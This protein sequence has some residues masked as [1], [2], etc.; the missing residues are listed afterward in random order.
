MDRHAPLP[1]AG[2]PA[3]NTIIATLACGSTSCPTVYHTSGGSFLV[4]GRSVAPES[5]GVELAD[6]EALVEL[7]EGLLDLLRKG[8]RRIE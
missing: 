2:L 1:H 3:E 5:V 4:Q 8:G 7:P 6:G